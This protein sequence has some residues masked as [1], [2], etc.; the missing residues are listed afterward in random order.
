MIFPQNVSQLEAMLQSPWFLAA[1]VWSMVVKGIALWQASQLRQKIWFVALFV[2]NT[3]GILELI[4]LLFVAKA[5][6]EVKWVQEEG[7]RP[8][9][10]KERK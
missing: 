10:K 1:L 6:V 7:T 8:K 3:F 9:P 4:Y 5:I 2:V